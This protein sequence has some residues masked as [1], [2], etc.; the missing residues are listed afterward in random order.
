[1]KSKFRIIALLLAVVMMFTS[2]EF[3]NNLLGNVEATT[4]TVTFE[5]D[6]GSQ[7]DSQV[8]KEGEQVIMPTAPTREGYIFEG[9]FSN[10]GLTVSYKFSSSV[11]ENITLYAKWSKD[12]RGPL[13]L[14]GENSTSLEEIS[15]WYTYTEDEMM[16]TEALVDQM[17][18]LSMTATIEEVEEVYQQFEDAFYHLAQQMTTASLI[19]YCNMSDEEAKE[20]HLKIMDEFYDLQDKYTQTC[21][22][23]YLESPIGEELFAD[24]S[25]DEI[26]ELLDY[27][28][29]IVA[30]KKEVEEL[31]VKYNDLNDQALDFSE[32][33]VE[34]YIQI[35]T[36]NNEI[37]RLCG[38]DNYYEYAT[39]EVYGRDY[40]TQDLSVFRKFVKENVSVRIQGLYNKYAKYY[41]NMSKNESKTYEAFSSSPF[42]ST[43]TN[44][45][46]RYLNSLE[47]VMG[48]S[49]RDVF[50][51]KNC[52]FSDHEKSHPTAFQTWLYEDEQPFCLFGSNG[53][54]AMTVVHEI[55]HYYA[56][57][58]NNDL[59]SYDLLETH[60]QGNEFL[61]LNYCKEY[62]PENVHKT[63]VVEQIWMTYIT[64]LMAT[65][66]DDFEQRIYEEETVE[67]WTVEQFDA[68]MEEVCEYYG[69][70]ASWINSMLVTDAYE[71][72]KL[73]A[74]SNPVYYV[75]YALSGVAALNIY[76]MVEQ[77]KC[78]AFD[79]YTILVENVNI[80]DGFIGALKKAGLHT[81]FESEAYTRIVEMIR[82]L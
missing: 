48:E 82:K 6:G 23:I 7:V 37:A 72:W 59:Q 54:S 34:L 19:Y 29:K 38:Y 51:N 56:A 43:K 16:A 68:V 25:V 64:I 24:W 45:L 55:G 50:E 79:A 52:I 61:F 1:M 74:V 58:Q 8:V 27:D 36:K 66:V 22:T 62:L 46:L 65:M 11:F 31:Q 5:T 60:S 44:Y 3:I 67:D 76:A 81:P 71:Y 69:S 49:M 26:Q 2:C 73:V 32:K 30:L 28:P 4:Y 70:G 9:W 75:S 40:D 17:L 47:G 53:Q 18:L 42:D 33:T 15:A 20:R 14:R 77:D 12:I 35:V 13:F 80:E 21:R 63:L 39:K 10:S 41:Q 78:A 57:L